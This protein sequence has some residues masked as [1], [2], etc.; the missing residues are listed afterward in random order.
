MER[1]ALAAARFWSQGCREAKSLPVGAA[2]QGRLQEAPSPLSPAPSGTGSL[3]LPLTGRAGL[4][5]QPLSPR[6]GFQWLACG[7]GLAPGSDS[8]CFPP[9]NARG[10]RL[11]S[12]S[13]SQSVLGS[14]RKG[15]AG[16][17]VSAPQR[18]RVLVTTAT[19]PEG[20]GEQRC[21]P[22]RGERPEITRTRSETPRQLPFSRRTKLSAAPG[23]HC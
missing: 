4:P 19:F 21:Q 18:S 5:P 9:P 23:P 10:A 8:A 7:G 6:G 13:P 20:A 16:R 11:G 3:V 22:H 15:S 1:T 14:K 17:Q 2:S 12:G